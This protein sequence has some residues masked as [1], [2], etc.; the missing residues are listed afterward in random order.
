M[1]AASNGRLDAVRLLL[2][3]GAELNRGDSER[4]T[5]LLHA[6]EAQQGQVVEFLKGR[7]AVTRE[8]KGLPANIKGVRPPTLPPEEF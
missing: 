1:E 8:P 7:N 6:L 2:D 4:R 5:A 3:R